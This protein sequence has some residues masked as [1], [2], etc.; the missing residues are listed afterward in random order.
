MRVQQLNNLDGSLMQHEVSMTLPPSW[1]DS[2]LQGYPRPICTIYAGTGEE[3]HT[4]MYIVEQIQEKNNDSIRPGQGLNYQL[5]CPHYAS[6]L[7]NKHPRWLQNRFTLQC[8]CSSCK[9]LYC[10]IPCNIFQAFFNII[11]CSHTCNL[12]QNF[13]KFGRNCIVHVCISLLL[14]LFFSVFFGLWFSLALPDF[15]QNKNCKLV[16]KHCTDQYYSF[17][18]GIQEKH[19]LLFILYIKHKRACLSGF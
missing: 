12:M 7:H 11:H 10:M 17:V 9:R 1:D 18:K 13:R 6:A 15:V 4:K 3:E 19:C 5:V 16:F 14:T 8:K 2:P